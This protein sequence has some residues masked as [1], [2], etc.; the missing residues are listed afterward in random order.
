MLQGCV[1]LLRHRRLDGE[2]ALRRDLA[3]SDQSQRAARL[4]RVVAQRVWLRV[5]NGIALIL[6]LGL[7]W[8]HLGVV[9]GQVLVEILLVVNRR[10]C[11]PKTAWSWWSIAI[12]LQRA[13]ADTVAEQ[14][15]LVERG[16]SRQLCVTGPFQRE[17]NIPNF[18]ICRDTPESVSL[19]SSCSALTA[20]GLVLLT[21]SDFSAWST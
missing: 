18:C 10:D 5:E 20:S 7:P 15:F 16:L 14:E 8:R 1:R 9:R 19:T 21:N 17:E 12:V 2:L 3:R 6:G 13:D 11:L 4:F